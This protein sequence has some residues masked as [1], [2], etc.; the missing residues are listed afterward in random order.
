MAWNDL[1]YFENLEMVGEQIES[2][3]QDDEVLSVTLRGIM[4]HIEYCEEMVFGVTEESVGAL[5][6]EFQSGMHESLK[7]FEQNIYEVMGDVAGDQ[8]EVA[9][10]HL[11]KKTE[12]SLSKLDRSL[13]LLYRRE[14]W[15]KDERKNSPA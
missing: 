4:R 13:D 10:E 9:I 12:E 3:A 2:L 15:R 11:E 14:K 8:I 6:E 7:Q 5:K 1:G